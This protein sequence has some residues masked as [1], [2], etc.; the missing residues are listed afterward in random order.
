MDKVDIN[1]YLTQARKNAK[2]FGFNGDIELSDRK[3]K[4]LKFTDKSSG[5][6][7][8]FGSSKNFDKILYE[9]QYGKDFAEQKAK[10]YRARAKAVFDK[11]N[12]L[13]ASHL[14]WYVLW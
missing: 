11:S 13:S 2:K 6:V 8:H 1:A 10:Q 7:T 14:A 3:T 4:K 5:K 9:L 12:K